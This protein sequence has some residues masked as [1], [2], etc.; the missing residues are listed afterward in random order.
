MSV[1]PG[2][3]ISA[4]EGERAKGQHQ[5]PCQDC[6]FKRDSIKGWLGIMTPDEWVMCAHGV[7]QIDC[8]VHYGAQ[9]AGAA[10][11]RKN[12]CKLP[13]PGQLKLP[14]D[15]EAVFSSPM[16]FKEHHELK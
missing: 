16:Q 10:I 15:T 9:C 5:K 14:R 8:H 2:R 6:P 3:F 11:Y 12:V 7:T 13:L 4:D 1:R